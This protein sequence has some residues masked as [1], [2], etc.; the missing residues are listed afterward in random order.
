MELA[1]AA[2][3]DAVNFGLSAVIEESDGRISIAYEAPAACS[4]KEA[5]AEDGEDGE[6]EDSLS[7]EDVYNIV[8]SVYN[9]YEYELKWLREDIS[10]MREA[11]YKHANNGHLP[12]IGDAGLMKKALKN[13]GLEDSFEVKTPSVYVQY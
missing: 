11:F 6:E 13:L 3:K 10:Y 4:D 5:K 1:E 7:A 8:R 2:V 12:A 9:S